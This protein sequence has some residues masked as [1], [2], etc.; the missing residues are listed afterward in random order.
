MPDTPKAFPRG[1][2]I[3]HEPHVPDV[4]IVF[5]HGLTGDRD[6]TCC[7]PGGAPWPQVDLSRDLP[8]ARILTFGHDVYISNWKHVVSGN[9]L[10]SHAKNLLNDLAAYRTNRT[11]DLPIIF[12]AHSLGGLVVKDALVTAWRGEE[13][14]V[15]KIAVVSRFRRQIPTILQRL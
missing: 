7:V 11:Q 5:V 2:K 9:R 12:V 14:H 8:N 6:R 10:G 13:A 3:W 15:Q 1:I 4:D